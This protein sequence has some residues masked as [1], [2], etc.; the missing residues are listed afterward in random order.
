MELSLPDEVRAALTDEG[1]SDDEMLL[2][3]GDELLGVIGG[4]ALYELVK[5]LAR[6]GRAIANH[7]GRPGRLPPADV[8]ERNLEILRL[9]IVE[10]MSYVQISREVGL[11]S[12]RVPQLL[13]FY[14]GVDWSVRR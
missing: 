11:S 9:R 6:D 12:S 5:M 13:H 14:W 1:I 10:R 4:G 7:P 2:M 8:A 3:T